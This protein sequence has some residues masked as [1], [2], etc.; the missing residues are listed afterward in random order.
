M[1]LVYFRRNEKPLRSER[2]KKKKKCHL[3][4]RREENGIPT[5]STTGVVEQ[6]E[7]E[8]GIRFTK[9][10]DLRCLAFVFAR[11]AS[12]LPPPPTNI[13]RIERQVATEFRR[14]NATFGRSCFSCNP[15]PCFSTCSSYLQPLMGSVCN[16]ILMRRFSLCI[17]FDYH[18]RSKRSCFPSFKGDKGRRQSFETA[19]SITVPIIKILPWR[20]SISEKIKFQV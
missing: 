16:R 5:P 14:N 10:A 8:G 12:F 11:S 13:L 3:F 6:K 1:V 7:G 19:A 20:C 4:S 9:A 15:A 17:P 18:D 2:K